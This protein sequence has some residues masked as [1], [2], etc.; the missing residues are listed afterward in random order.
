MSISVS[1][2]R[3]RFPEF[4]DTEEY[5]DPR[6]NMFISDSQLLYMGTDELRWNGRY[7]IAQAYLSA[8]LLI[9][10][11]FSE[12]GDSSSK[13][14]SVSSKSAGGVSVTRSVVS[15]ERSD[16]DDFLMSTTYGQQFI[17]IRNMTFVG[18]TVANL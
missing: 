8:H 10:A 18:V 6:I 5:T 12:L 11:S 13:S 14:G 3:T 4:S 1:D 16:T 15:K 7:D 9:K 2:F 17:S